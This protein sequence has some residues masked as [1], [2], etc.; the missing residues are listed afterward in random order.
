MWQEVKQIYSDGAYRYF[1][2]LY[3]FLDIT[4]LTLY[5]AS[6]TMRFISMMKVKMPLIR[7]HN[8]IKSFELSLWYD[9]G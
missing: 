2:S 9:F 6:Y 4:M 1:D 5:V 8:G 7:Q 3:N